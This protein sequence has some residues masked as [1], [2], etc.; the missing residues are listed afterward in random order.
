MKIVNFYPVNHKLS[1]L[2]WNNLDHRW[3]LPRQGRTNGGLGDI[4]LC[5][6]KRKRN[7]ALKMH[8]KLSNFK[9][10]FTTL[11]YLQFREKT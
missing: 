5:L 11:S 9:N 2:R 4:P 3:P 6:G 7:S 10:F 8:E 1:L